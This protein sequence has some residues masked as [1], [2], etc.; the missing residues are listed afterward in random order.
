MAEARE[1][2]D[3]WI[4]ALVIV[5]T[6]SVV[7]L[8]IMQNRREAQNAGR[9]VP[10]LSLPLLEN[11]KAVSIERGRVTVVDFW[12]TWCVPCR[13]SMPRVQQ[14]W[15]EYKP[16][17]V[18]IYSVDTDDESPDRNAQ[19]REFLMQNHLTFPVVLDDGRASEAFAVAN[20]PTM[21]LVDKQGR[22]AWTHVG[23]LSGTREIELRA[24]ID[25]ALATN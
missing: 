6:G 17:G 16:R 3:A 11:G 5:A 4:W 25:R 21:L 22:V 19:V 20:I 23:A 14:L 18:E 8:A 15:Q 12:A 1:R 24:A 2:S 10:A 7:G 13:A 9:E